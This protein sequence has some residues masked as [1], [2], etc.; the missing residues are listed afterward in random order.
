MKI[1]ST[2]KKRGLSQYAIPVIGELEY[3]INQDIFV[4]ETEWKKKWSF[5]YFWKI[6]MRDE[7]CQIWGAE[8]CSLGG[9][10]GNI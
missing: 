2:K 6:P 1:D 5:F 9:W 7:K 10:K 4:I 3:I 8:K